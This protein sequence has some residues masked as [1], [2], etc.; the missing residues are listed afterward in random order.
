MKPNFSPAQSPVRA[1]EPG[2]QTSGHMGLQQDHPDLETHVF[3]TG[4]ARWRLSSQDGK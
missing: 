2:G 4:A 3:H 1:P